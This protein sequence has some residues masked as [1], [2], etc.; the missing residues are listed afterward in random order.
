[1]GIRRNLGAALTMGAMATTKLKEA[2][3][4]HQSRLELHQSI[5]ERF[6]ALCEN[7]MSKL[8]EMKESWNQAKGTLLTLGAMNVS[9]SGTLEYGWFKRTN[10]HEGQASEGAANLR[11][12]YRRFRSKHR[13]HDRSTRRCMVDGGCSRNRV[14]R[15]SDQRAIRGGRDQR[16][17]SMVRGRGS[18]GRR[19]G[20]GCCAVRAQRHW[21]RSRTPAPSF[22]WFKGSG[23][24]RTEGYREDQ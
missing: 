7:T 23:K 10:P 1:M 19:V 13:G 2:Q 21:P 4:G 6:N 15:S 9:A 14:H 12:T 24:I 3:E 11:R 5:V 18:S 20:D 22:R 16:H 8:A 17:R